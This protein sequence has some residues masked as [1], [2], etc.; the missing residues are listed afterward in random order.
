MKVRRVMAAMLLSVATAA[1]MMSCGGGDKPAE[2]TTEE[3]VVQTEDP[4]LALGQKIYEE[5]CVVCHQADGKG[6]PNVFPPVADSDYLLADK[7]RAVAQ[8]LNGSNEAMV[9]NGI[10]YTT[11]MPPQVD[12]K[13]EA[14]AV[15]N[16][17]LNAFGNDG[18]YITL[19]EVKDIVIAPRK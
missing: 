7:K 2:E 4:Q 10:T 15:T 1:I 3:A 18:G 19:E 6:T 14:V 13:E 11:P 5:K 17:I 8:I 9:V 12:T 16:Y